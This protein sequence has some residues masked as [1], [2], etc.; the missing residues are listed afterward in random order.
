MRKLYI[1]PI[2]VP[3]TKE[4]NFFM[5]PIQEEPITIQSIKKLLE[6]YF[7]NSKN[8]EADIEVHFW[9]NSFASLDKEKQKDILQLLEEYQKQEK[10][11]QVRINAQIQD[12]SR[13]NIKIWKKYKVKEISLQIFSM[14]TYL[15]E[16]IGIQDSIKHIQKV[17]KKLRWHGF[18][19][20]AEILIGMPEST[21]LDEQNTAKEI[22]KL[23]PHF[24]KI[25]PVVVEKQSEL[26]KRFQ[27][28]EYVALSIV[29]AVERCKEVAHIF[30]QN[31]IPEI[32]ITLPQ[33]SKKEN[34]IIAGPYHPEFTMLVEGAMWYDVILEK[35]KKMNTKVKEVEIKANPEDVPNMLGYKNENI[36]KLKEI[37]DVEVVITPNKE[38]KKGRFEMAM[39]KTYDDMVEEI[40]SKK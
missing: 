29:Q 2:Q 16:K 31:R 33:E 25:E 32:K 30:N 20:G 19:I 28:E 13:E 38:M 26:E 4:K 17:A 14:S 24:V 22:I 11:K 18:T 35:I 8:E 15:L 40:Q 21:K 39:T 6:Y 27:K 34:N 3:Y 9:G 1:L 12:I 10:I 36:E 23:K 37:Y 7:K 5:S